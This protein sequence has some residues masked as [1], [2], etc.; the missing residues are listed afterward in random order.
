MKPANLARLQYNHLDYDNENHC[1]WGNLMLEKKIIACG[2]N[3]GDA[4]S[5]IA[6]CKIIQKEQTITGAKV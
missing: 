2:I 1:R 6:A 5:I 3:E 4:L